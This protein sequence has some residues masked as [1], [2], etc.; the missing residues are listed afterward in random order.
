MIEIVEQP[1]SEQTRIEDL[2]LYFRQ[3]DLV[4]PF[5]LRRVVSD[6]SA[7]YRTVSLHSQQPG[8]PAMPFGDPKPGK[9]GQ[10]RRGY[11]PVFDR[12]VPLRSQ[13]VAAVLDAW[14]SGE[15][16]SGVVRVQRRLQLWPPE[17]DLLNGWEMSG[18]VRLKSLHWVP[19]VV[20]LWGK[21]D[22][23]MRIRV[24][25]LSRVLVSKRYFRLG[26]SVIDRLCKDLA[27]TPVD[28]GGA[29][30]RHPGWS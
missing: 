5:D 30:L 6:L 18:R 15:P 14:W 12:M 27:K 23:F 16:K 1:R 4:E 13:R 19:V 17:G 22:G 8:V 11:S 26:N 28:G 3:P 20:E 21:Y 25:P 29:V 2:P 10:P 24:T 9:A 7:A